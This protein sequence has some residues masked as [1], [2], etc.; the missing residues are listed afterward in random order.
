MKRIFITLFRIL[1]NGEN[2]PQRHI[3]GPWEMLIP[4]WTGTEFK[5][6]EGVSPI[7]RRALIAGDI[8]LVN[9]AGGWCTLMTTDIILTMTENRKATAIPTPDEMLAN[10]NAD[11][12]KRYGNHAVLLTAN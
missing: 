8:V 10:Y 6:P 5:A 7:Y 1:G 11:L 9:S 4:I 3:S 12:I 2:T